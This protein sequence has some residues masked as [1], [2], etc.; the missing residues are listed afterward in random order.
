MKGFKQ[1]TVFDLFD[2]I[3]APARNEALKNGIFF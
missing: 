3:F 2:W 1:H